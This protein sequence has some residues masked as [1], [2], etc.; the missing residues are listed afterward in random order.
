M[1]FLREPQREP[2]FRVPG[3]VTALIAVL[4][5]AHLARVW[6]FSAATSEQ[7]V[8]DCGFAPLRLAQGAGSSLAETVLPFLGYVFLHA[9]ATHLTINCLW[10]LAFGPVVARRW[11]APAFLLF[12]LAGGAA[13]ALAYL[14]LAWGQAGIIIGASGAISALMA[15]AMRM[16]R[17]PPSLPPGLVEGPLLPLWSSQ[18]LVTSAVWVGINLLSGLAGLDP[19]G[20]THAIAWQAHLGGYFAGL[21]LTGPIDHFLRPELESPPPP[22][23]LRS[24]P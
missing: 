3:V 22:P 5:A 7:I 12:F 8:A 23:Q 18:I 20:G 2:V 24:V 13:S 14:A 16:L 6:L 11:G 21:F 10:L 19:S 15:A 17:M 1:A 4:V 9:D